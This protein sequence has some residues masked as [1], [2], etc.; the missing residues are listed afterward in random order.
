VANYTGQAELATAIQEGLAAQATGDEATA[1]EKLTRA[2][3]LAQETGNEGTMKLLSKVV[4][5]ETD[6]TVRLKK[7]AREDLV[8]LDTRSTRTQRIGG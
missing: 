5:Q 1:T 8:E 3:K 6:G 4:T 7:A 2:V